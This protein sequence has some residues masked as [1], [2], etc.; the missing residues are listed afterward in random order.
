MKQLLHTLAIIGILITQSCSNR[1]DIVF[2]AF[3]ELHYIILYEKEYEFEMQYNGINSAV[4]T[5]IL[6]ND[7]ILLTYHEHQFEEFDPNLKL[8]RQI[9]IE[10]KSKTVHSIDN[11]IPFCANIAVDKR[12]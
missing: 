4:E 11:T 5:Y 2:S 6:K 3:D 10:K 7:I 12:N 8:T 9:L 1:K